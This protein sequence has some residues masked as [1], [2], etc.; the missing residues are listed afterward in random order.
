[1]GGSVLCAEGRQTILPQLRDDL[2]LNWRETE[3]QGALIRGKKRD[4]TFYKTLKFPW[5]S[6]K[7]GQGSR[8]KRSGCHIDPIDR[9]PVAPAREENEVATFDRDCSGDG[10]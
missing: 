9:C 10:R 8:A 5:G 2:P 6:S 1:M 7:N 3:F 4:N